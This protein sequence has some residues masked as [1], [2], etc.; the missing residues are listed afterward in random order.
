MGGVIDLTAGSRELGW[1]GR[2][3]WPEVIAL[4]TDNA[5]YVLGTQAAESGLQEPEIQASPG[6]IWLA[7]LYKT[8]A[9][10]IA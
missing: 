9:R 7:V 8:L 2:K 5:E 6:D 1:H 4:P 10:R 3:Q